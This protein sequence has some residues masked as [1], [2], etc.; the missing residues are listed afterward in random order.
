MPQKY[1]KLPAVI[2][3][4]LYHA[5]I[6]GMGFFELQ[7]FVGSALIPYFISPDSTDL[8]IRTLEGDMRVSEGDYVIKGVNGEF[9]PCKPDIFVKTYELVQDAET[10]KP[11]PVDPAI[12]AELPEEEYDLEDEYVCHC[13]DDEYQENE[14]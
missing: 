7:Q 3:A 14:D 8:Y 1:R 4:Q 13:F 9:Y 12:V 6:A 5:G 11:L 10:L 2:E